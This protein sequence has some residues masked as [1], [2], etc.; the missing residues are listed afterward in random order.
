MNLFKTLVLNRLVIFFLRESKMI[1]CLSELK[2]SPIT[3]AVALSL[4]L[5]STY[6][7]SSLTALVRLSFN[8]WWNELSYRKEY[9]GRRG[10]NLS[11]TLSLVPLLEPILSVTPKENWSAFTG[12]RANNLLITSPSETEANTNNSEAFTWGRFKAD[13][14]SFNVRLLIPQPVLQNTHGTMKMSAIGQAMGKPQFPS[15]QKPQ[16]PTV[17]VE[18]TH[19][20][21]S[22]LPWVLNLTYV[23]LFQL[24][25]L[26]TILMTGYYALGCMLIFTPLVSQW[27]KYE[28]NISL[29]NGK[30]RS[31]LY[32]LECL[33]DT[34]IKIDTSKLAVNRRVVASTTNAQVPWS[35]HNL[36]FH[37]LFDTSFITPNIMS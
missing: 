1:L 33:S 18:H 9:R 17:W 22:S 31:I 28:T 2:Y 4:I 7:S 34:T 16:H 11:S 30:S 5:V 37:K 6:T 32:P 3:P 35:R 25:P 19:L 15:S 8:S 36:A 20:D 13:A 10:P 27:R 21:T 14:N 26:G 23:S 29:V 12:R 24:V